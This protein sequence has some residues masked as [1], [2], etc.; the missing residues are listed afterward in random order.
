MF[1]FTLHIECKCMRKSVRVFRSGNATFIY[2]RLTASYRLITLANN[3]I[4]FFALAKRLIVPYAARKLITWCGILYSAGAP[5]QWPHVHQWDIHLSHCLHPIEGKSCSLDAGIHCNLL[6]R[7]W[8]IFQVNCLSVG[9]RWH[10]LCLSNNKGYGNVKVQRHQHIYL[11]RRWKMQSPNEHEEE[12][13][14]TVSE[15]QW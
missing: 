8:Q 12:T 1:S 5:W 14:Y 11:S 4:I 3:G 7:W 13:N 15:Q 6:M 9:V 2:D 10:F